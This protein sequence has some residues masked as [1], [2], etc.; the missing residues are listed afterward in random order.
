[1]TTNFLLLLIS[2][3]ALLFSANLCV[4]GAIYIAKYFKIPS[5]I[6]GLTIVALGTSL[7]ELI[8]SI[9][10]A[11]KNSTAL[12]LGNVIGSN[13]ANIGLIVGLTALIKPIS[14]KSSTVS[15][16]LPIMM[17][18]T[19]L[20]SLLIIDFHLSKLDGI[21]LAIGFVLFFSWVIIRALKN[22]KNY[23]S[24]IIKQEFNKELNF[25]HINILKSFLIFIIGI[26]LMPISG[27]KL[28]HYSIEIART[29]NISDE[30]IGL[31]ILAIGSS[32]PELATSIISILKKEDDIAIGN[33][34]G[35][36]IFNLLLVML[37]PAI[38]AP[39]KINPTIIYR[40]LS[41]MIVLSLMLILTS[42]NF[43]GVIENKITRFE[44]L[45]LLITYITYL[46]ILIWNV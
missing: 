4:T 3:A 43:S 42:I 2:L 38:L 7:P 15:R 32:A 6:I 45:I 13:I 12:A 46:G 16:E 14:I 44:G 34:V 18:A 19:I 22:K 39:A 10:A 1:M 41:T 30:I 31:T 26:I 29:F 36:N 9:F 35:S 5:L 17:A 8:I 24:D 23:K 37:A 11:L 33:I 28:V 20:F 25:K 21:I 27:D 40:D